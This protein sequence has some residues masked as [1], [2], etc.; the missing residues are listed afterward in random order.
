MSLLPNDTF[1]NAGRA[2]WAAA[3]SGG[4]GGGSTLTSPASV[5]PADDGTASFTVAAGNTYADAS[6]SV[7]AGAARVGTIGLTGEDATMN[8]T[9]GRNATL[10]LT[11]GFTGQA[12][13]SI[14]DTP[15]IGATLS[16]GTGGNAVSLQ[17]SSL[18]PRL[19]AFVGGSVP[20]TIRPTSVTVNGL[21]LENIGS[22]PGA[23]T[24]QNYIAPTLI[25]GGNPVNVTDYPLPAPPA[26]VVNV[27]WWVYSIGS[28]STT[29]LYSV[30]AGVS[31]TAYWNG[32]AFTQGGNVCQVLG[33]SAGWTAG[34][35][36]QIF[37]A[38]NQQTLQF[39][40]A[41]AT[42]LVGI[43]VSATQLTGAVPGF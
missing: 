26:G 31:V 12:I 3:G 39:F 22:V 41:N 19:N 8:I 11:P 16:M 43:Y 28:N 42:P 32:T 7:N 10:A 33:G 35:F 15:N 14:G 17:T 24:G 25:N 18:E 40:Y 23:I 6:L 38:I 13:L 5:T 29:D 30:Q 9:A 1:V 37:K 4:G 27:G 34:H 20:L 21:T 2:L 36:A